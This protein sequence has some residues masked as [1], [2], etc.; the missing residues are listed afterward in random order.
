MNTHPSCKR[1]DWEAK[2]RARFEESMPHFQVVAQR[3][4]AEVEKRK[5]APLPN[6]AHHDSA[7]FAETVNK[8]TPLIARGSTGQTI[9]EISAKTN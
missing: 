1:S 9:K 4:V 8:Y 7:A 3:T 5:S 2:E 6:L